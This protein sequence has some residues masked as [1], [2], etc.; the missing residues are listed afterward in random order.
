MNKIQPAVHPEGLSASVPSA[1]SCEAL[2]RL[3]SARHI[4][5]SST[6]GSERADDVDGAV[7]A[8]GANGAN[9][10]G[11]GGLSGTFMRECD[12]T[13]AA[14][15]PSRAEASPRLEGPSVAG[16]ALGSR[17]K[18]LT[19]GRQAVELFLA[20]GGGFGGDGF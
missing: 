8:N 15:L 4:P 16:R 3:R 14:S 9:G 18:I 1:C 19:F 17:L 10:G 20:R 7:G 5:P 6:D 12:I 13:G 2:G 11:G